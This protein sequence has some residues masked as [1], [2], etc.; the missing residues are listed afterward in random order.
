[1]GAWRAFWST[2]PLHRA[3][4]S[5]VLAFPGERSQGRPS[6]IEAEALLAIH[7]L[8]VRRRRQF[9]P[10]FREAGV[11]FVA[12]NQHLRAID[13]NERALARLNPF[14]RRCPSDTCID[15]V[16]AYFKR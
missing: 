15:E 8:D 3:G 1:V 5:Y 16:K 13:R 11:R 14:I 6:G 2:P 12:E 10:S 9:G 7:S 4:T